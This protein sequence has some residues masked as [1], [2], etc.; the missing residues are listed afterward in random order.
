MKILKIPNLELNISNIYCIGRNYAEHA[1][2][3]GNKVPDKPLVFLKPTSA[4]CFNNS[5]III[6]PQSEEV[7]HEV[8]LV[9]AI[10]NKGKNIKTEH[11]LSYIA[12]VGIGLDLTARDIQ[13]KAKNNAHPWAIAKGFDTFAP[14][15]QF[16]DLNSVNSL[17]NLDLKLEVNGEIRQHGNTKDMIHSCAELIA[18]LS[19]YFTLY[20]GDLIFT[21]TPKGVS[22][23]KPGDTIKAS[24]NN[25]LIQLDLTVR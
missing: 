9:L 2:E 13:Q 7:H 3:L 18:Y 8:E 21:G 5:E 22:Q 4:I 24:L 19:N 12:G 16:I 11:A 10:G 14:I 25:N 20:P 17:Q 23:I 6:P 15:S 1:K